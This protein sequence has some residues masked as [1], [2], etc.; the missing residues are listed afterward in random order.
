MENENGI[1][2][3]VAEPL[4]TDGP[5]SKPLFYKSVFYVPRQFPRPSPLY[6]FLR[7]CDRRRSASP[8]HRF[9]TLL[10]VLEDLGLEM[11]CRHLASLD[12]SD[13]VVVSLDDELS[14]ALGKTSVVLSQLREVV[15]LLVPPSPVLRNDPHFVGAEHAAFLAFAQAREGDVRRYALRANDDAA[16]DDLPFDGFAMEGVFAPVSQVEVSSNGPVTSVHFEAAELRHGLG[17]TLREREDWLLLRELRPV[18]SPLDRI[19]RLFGLDAASRNF[20]IES[21]LRMDPREDRFSLPRLP[22]W[23]VGPYHPLSPEGR[24]LMAGGLGIRSGFLRLGET[25]DL[26]RSHLH[27]LSGASLTGDRHERRIFVDLVS[28]LEE[29]S[30]FEAKVME[31]VFVGIRPTWRPPSDSAKR[32]YL[33]HAAVALFATHVHGFD[34][35]AADY[36]LETVM[37]MAREAYAALFPTNGFPPLYA[38]PLRGPLG[39]VCG[40]DRRLKA[41]VLR[42][43]VLPIPSTPADRPALRLLETTRQRRRQRRARRRLG[44]VSDDDHGASPDLQPSDDDGALPNLWSYESMPPTSDDDDEDDQGDGRPPSLLFPAGMSEFSRRYHE[45]ST[46]TTSLLAEATPVPET[47]ECLDPDRQ[48]VVCKYARATVALLHEKIYHLS[49]CYSCALRYQSPNCP[50]C[51]ESIVKRV[52]MVPE[53]SGTEEAVVAT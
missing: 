26:L 2:A 27:E 15:A 16:A 32:F 20:W 9:S 45:A 25:V 49:L 48:C 43:M 12:R 11:E 19:G 4:T 6:D 23:C 35:E 21:E 36:D 53:S 29:A 34:E 10:W 28:E 41:V 52:L 24:I 8:L 22:H 42:Y 17:E 50:L 3:P 5:S 37:A 47:D 40:D 31:R 7:R 14:A 30:D 33:R 51:R 38:F 1:S 46:T 18:L 39:T 13:T 44:G